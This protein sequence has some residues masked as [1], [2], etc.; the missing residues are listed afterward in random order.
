[1]L[2]SSRSSSSGIDAHVRVR[3]D[4]H[5]DLPVA[6][7]CDRQEP[8]AEVGL[9]RR[10]HTDA[11]ARVTKE[12][13]LA[14]VGMRRVHDRRPRPEATGA[15]EHLDRPET[16]FSEALLDLARLL[17]GV[18]VQRQLVL[19][20]I[21][22]ELVQ[23]L[24]RARPNG[25]GSDPDPNAGVAQRLELAAGTRQP[26][27]GGTG[28]CRRAGSTRRDRR[29]RSRPRR[30]PRPRPSP[31]RSRGSG[32][33]RPRCSRLRAARGTPRRTRSGSPR[34]SV[35][36]PARSSRRARPRSR[37]RGRGPAMRVE[38]HGNGR[39]RIPA[40][41]ARTYPV[42]VTRAQVPNALT[43]ARLRADPG[44]R[45]ADPLE[46][47]RPLLAG[48]NRLR[49]RRDHRPGRRLSSPAAGT[50]SRRSASSPTRSPTG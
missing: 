50:S 30:P 6:H 27:A 31:P 25:V 36:R 11:G 8:V 9:G 29:T 49:G 10:A 1:M 18:D 20:G 37:R 14:A 35:T 16:V 22:A 41:S 33:L 47:R 34:R 43:I 13:E 32:T 40:G 39:R 5:A 26:T 45:R 7:A 2:S 38:T 15:R 44:L 21:P 19:G 48:R 17:V 23:R 12:V 28:G 46:R 4:A 3:A 24:R 42:S